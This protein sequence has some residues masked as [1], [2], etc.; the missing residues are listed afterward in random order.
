LQEQNQK[1]A[2]VYEERWENLRALDK[3]LGDLHSYIEVAKRE[4]GPYRHYGQDEAYPKAHVAVLG[5][6]A[7]PPEAAI[8]LLRAGVASKTITADAAAEQLA[9]LL[10]LPASRRIQIGETVKAA[11]EAGD[12]VISKIRPY[13]KRS[14]QVTKQHARKTIAVSSDV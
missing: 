4:I 13:L 12:D 2:R 14:T 10:D 1:Q 6:T 3:T 11:F 8:E 5:G 9:E 7:T